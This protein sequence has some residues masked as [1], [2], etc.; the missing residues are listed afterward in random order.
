VRPRISNPAFDV[1]TTMTAAGTSLFAVN[2]RF[3][4]EVTPDTTYSVIRFNRP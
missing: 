4:V 3:G 2:A 1:P